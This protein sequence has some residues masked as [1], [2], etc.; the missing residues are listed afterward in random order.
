MVCVPVFLVSG[1]VSCALRK[2]NGGFREVLKETRVLKE[3]R[4]SGDNTS[5][6]KPTWNEGVVWLP[7]ALQLVPTVSYSCARE[8]GKGHLWRI[9]AHR[10]MMH[11][12]VILFVV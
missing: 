11:S 12:G 4:A 8:S 9:P 7:G 3:K 10:I 1:R 5:V 2:K 6:G